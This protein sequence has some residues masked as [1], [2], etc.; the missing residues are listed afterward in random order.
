MV[1]CC[2]YSCM[3]TLWLLLCFLP[4]FLA[5]AALLNFNFGN[6]LMYVIHEIFLAAKE[7]RL[8]VGEVFIMIW[9]F[10]C[11]DSYSDLSNVL[12]FK[13]NRWLHLALAKV[14]MNL[15]MGRLSFRMATYKIGSHEEKSNLI[16][17]V[18]DRKLGL[19]ILDQ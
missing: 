5:R 6:H 1:H 10:L 2:V 16:M 9:S 4:L 8:K 19:E 17:I 15:Q 3:I 14:P 18:Y 7:G 11:R 12:F 13:A